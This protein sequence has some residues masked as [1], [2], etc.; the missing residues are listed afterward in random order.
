M[1]LSTDEKASEE[2]IEE[3]SKLYGIKHSIIRCGSILVRDQI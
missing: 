3:Y 2:F 1:D